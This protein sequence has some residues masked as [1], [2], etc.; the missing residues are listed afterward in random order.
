V[1]L[2]GREYV[3][4]DPAGE[5]RVGRL[6]AAEGKVAT[7]PGGPLRFDDL[8]GGEGGVP[9]VADLAV[10]DEVGER[11]ERL[12][13]VGVGVGAVDLVQVDPV[14]VQPSQGGLDAAD[15]PAAGRAAPV[16]V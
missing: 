12:V 7:V 14:G 8:G 9:E 3:V 6:F 10:G 11:G 1:L 15:D 16:G 2:T 5:D 13:D 4:L